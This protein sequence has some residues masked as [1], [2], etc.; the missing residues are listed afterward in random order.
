MPCILCHTNEWNQ[1][2][3]TQ[4]KSYLCYSINYAIVLNKQWYIPGGCSRVKCGKNTNKS[5]R[6]TYPSVLMNPLTVP[7][8][9]RDTMS[10]MCKKLDAESDML[11]DVRMLEARTLQVSSWKAGVNTHFTHSWSRTTYRW[12]W[13]SGKWKNPPQKSWMCSRRCRPQMSEL[14]KWLDVWCLGLYLS[15]CFKPGSNF[16]KSKH[17]CRGGS[18][19]EPLHLKLL[20]HFTSMRLLNGQLRPLH[21]KSFITNS[22]CWE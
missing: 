18:T 3:L 21:N 7:S 13:R 2:K 16:V 11:A 12:S 15:S 9:Y 22:Q 20:E 10:P 5:M 14:Q 1:C 19:N 17:A 4:L 6:V 8:A